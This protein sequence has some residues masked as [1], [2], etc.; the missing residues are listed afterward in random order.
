[1]TSSTPPN[2]EEVV[3]EEEIGDAGPGD[4][5][6]LGDMEGHL[7][8]QTNN[9]PIKR[10]CCTRKSNLVI[11]V[12]LFL[13]ELSLDIID[14]VS[15]SAD[16]T[17]TVMIVWLASVA[18]V[19]VAFYIVQ[20]D[21][22]SAFE[23]VLLF[24]SVVFCAIRVYLVFAGLTTP[25]T[26]P[27]LCVNGLNIAISLPAINF[28]KFYPTWQ[29][30]FL[31]IHTVM[32][33]TGT[34]ILFDLVIRSSSIAI[35]VTNMDVE[36]GGIEIRLLHA[37]VCVAAFEAF[38]LLFFVFSCER[39][40]EDVSAF[41]DSSIERIL[42]VLIGW[43][44][45]TIS[46]LG[47][48][49]IRPACPTSPTPSSSR[50]LTRRTAITIE[51]FFRYGI[52]L[53][54]TVAVKLREDRNR[55]EDRDVDFWLAAFS[56][57]IFFQFLLVVRTEYLVTPLFIEKNQWISKAIED[58]GW[59]RL[60]PWCWLRHCDA[61][62]DITVSVPERKK[63]A[64]VPKTPAPGL[65]TPLPKIRTKKTV[66]V[67]LSV[68]TPHHW[69][70]LAPMT[71]LPKSRSPPAITKPAPARTPEGLSVL[72]PS[73]IV[74]SWNPAE[75]RKPDESQPA[76]SG[77]WAD[78]SDEQGGWDIPEEVEEERDWDRVER[79]GISVEKRGDTPP[80]SEEEEDSQR[81]S[82]IKEN[83]VLPNRLQGLRV[84]LGPPRNQDAGSHRKPSTELTNWPEEAERGSPQ[85]SPNQ[86]I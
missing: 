62:P 40:L 79:R 55:L 50:C 26:Y 16:T 15:R 69:G 76:P 39:N 22:R 42:R 10:K 68:T 23:V 63:I 11:M 34:G 32:S 4:G 27:A 31:G 75:E 35:F 47:I 46:Q 61:R 65:R 3:D 13:M 30:S 45:L 81:L 52:S 70:K 80:S 9:Q 56:V 37:L 25:W 12:V 51:H 38:F 7:E 29:D 8:A 1:M 19:S 73:V 58:L 85:T 28:Y 43:I 21:L 83:P 24:K 72:T 2:E 64:F 49:I 53:A 18:I 74:N 54:A 5:T 17:Q 82:P 14:L 78:L 36:I 86:I 57:L 44:F 59:T 84:K 48:L 77:G 20:R 60:P 67:K 6:L 66:S 33:C 71:P 41:T